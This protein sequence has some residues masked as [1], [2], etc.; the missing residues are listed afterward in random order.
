MKAAFAVWDQRIAPVF[1][2]ARRVHL[3]EAQGGRLV[4]EHDETLP[5]GIP[6]QRVM[7]LVE[8]GIDALVCGAVSHSLQSLIASYGIRVW[9]FVAGEL[10]DVVQA[11]LASRLDNP[12]YA[13]PGCQRRLRTRCGCGRGR[14]AGAGQGRRYRGSG[15]GPAREGGR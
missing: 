12:T 1:D 9:P 4:Q 3:V 2:V 5:E 6:A 8:L 10:D 15:R 11:W 13:M 14:G 7:R